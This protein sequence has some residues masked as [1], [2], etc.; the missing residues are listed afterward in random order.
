MQV[1]GGTV[2][3]GEFPQDAALRE[4]EVEV[5]LNNLSVVVELGALEYYHKQKL[6]PQERHYFHLTSPDRLPDSWKHTVSSGSSDQ[7]R[8]FEFFWLPL[9]QAY[10]L[11][12]RQGELAFSLS[13]SF[14]AELSTI[15]KYLLRL[16]RK[17]MRQNLLPNDAV[18]D[19]C[20]IFCADTGELS[21]LTELTLDLRKPVEETPAGTTYLL[22]EPITY[23]GDAVSLIK[24]R[25]PDT[26]KIWQ[27]DIDYRV[28][29]YAATKEF[30]SQRPDLNVIIREN[31][32]MVELT[33]FTADAVLYFS[34]P[35]LSSELTLKG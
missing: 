29:D 1:P 35:S 15:V 10:E 26:N 32:E 22:G 9:D 25:T 21:R 2:D 5:G 16:D 20:A 14:N 24:L 30:L 33:D 18:P 34:N 6:E 7:G 11:A 8:L 17:Y 3:E 4:V 13:A 12:G 19:V 27:G 23:D 28:P 31:Y